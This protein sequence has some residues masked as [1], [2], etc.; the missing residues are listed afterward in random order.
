M[1]QEIDKNVKT[2]FLNSLDDFGNPNG[3]NIDKLISE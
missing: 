1:L 3:F 2:A